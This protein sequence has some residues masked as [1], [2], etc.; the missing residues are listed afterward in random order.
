MQEFQNGV[1]FKHDGSRLKLYFYNHIKSRASIGSVEFF[2]ELSRCIECCVK[3]T[4][5]SHEEIV[6]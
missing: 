4:R 2:G 3:L 1:T 6:L 5:G